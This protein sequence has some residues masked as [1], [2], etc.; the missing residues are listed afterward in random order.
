MIPTP[1]RLFV[2]VVEVVGVAQ[3]QVMEAPVEVEGL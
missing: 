2:S 3:E 1:S